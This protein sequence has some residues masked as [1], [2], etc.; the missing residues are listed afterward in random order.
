MQLLDAVH[1]KEPPGTRSNAQYSRKKDPR[2]EVF[3][4]TY[5]ED[6][7]ASQRFAL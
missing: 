4:V 3:F 7:T 6:V 1:Y 2:K 5:I